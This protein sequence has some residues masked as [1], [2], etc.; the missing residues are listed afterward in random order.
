MNPRA[1]S[2]LLPGLFLCLAVSALAAGLG[3]AG[4]V[5]A[6]VRLI[7][8]FTAAIVLGFCIRTFVRL[9]QACGPG[10]RCGTV[11]VLEIAVFLLGFSIDLSVFE[12][13][14]LAFVG[15]VMSFVVV[16]IV[17]S[18]AICRAIGL[19]EDLAVL[20]ACGNAIC[21]NAAIAAVAPVVRA[22]NEDVVAAITFSSIL[23]VAFVI[24][25]P[26][27]APMIG[28]STFQ[29]GTFAGLTVYAVPQVV[30]ATAPVSMLS[31]Q[32]GTAV[33]LM[34]V[35]MLVPAVLAAP[36]L[37]RNRQNRH[38]VQAEPR[39]SLIR[40]LPWF[41]PGFLVAALLNNLGYVPDQVETVTSEVSRGFFVVAM[42]GLG[43]SVDLRRLLKVGPRL[44]LGVSASLVLLSAVSL[45]FAV[46][47]A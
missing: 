36:L 29:F 34:R 30:A 43:L 25:L 1:L 28:L 22:G 45:L 32:V 26:V 8:S 41:I 27:M 20:V 14:N 39:G 2:G 38:R 21:G 37:L 6:G 40:T 11:S 10:I 47:L 35:L 19:P 46:T 13:S 31:A 12:G 7:D 4:S 42:A 3:K 16:M 33:K 44:I 15:M 5:L 24:A 23:G 17:T 9:P 18:F